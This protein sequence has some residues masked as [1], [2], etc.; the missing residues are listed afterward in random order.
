MP[1]TRTADIPRASP[2]GAGWSLGRALKDAAIEEPVNRWVHRPL[3]FLLIRPLERVRLG[4]TPNR[5]TLLSGVAGVAAGACYY[6]ALEGGVPFT[7]A[8]AALLFVAVIL[9]CADGMLARLRG[10]TSR[11]GD[12]M[13]DSVVGASVWWGV[14][15]TLCGQVGGDLSRVAC[16]LALPTIL[17]HC[18]IYDSVKNR[19]L[20]AIGREQSARAAAGAVERT[21]DVLYRTVYGALAAR[22]TRDEDVERLH[23]DAARR[24]LEPALRLARWLGLGSHLAVIYLATQ[25]SVLDPRFTLAAVVLLILVG[26]NLLM[27][28]ALV[29]WQRA[30]RRLRAAPEVLCAP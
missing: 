16:L 26:S 5:I 6:H 8:G 22:T 12:G 29:A 25:L 13:V 28:A 27:L 15:H 21:F 24:E 20:H 18:A 19:Y 1:G 3:A 7:L 11:F 9:D 4:I 30:W 14:S 17:A 10:E 23:P 2:D